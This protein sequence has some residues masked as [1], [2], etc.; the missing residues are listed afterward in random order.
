MLSVV[1]DIPGYFQKYRDGVINKTVLIGG[2]NFVHALQTHYG[3]I[4]KDSTLDL[5]P[6]LP[7]CVW[8]P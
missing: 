2:I 8:L 5:N 3:I 4:K 6:R 7:V 1:F